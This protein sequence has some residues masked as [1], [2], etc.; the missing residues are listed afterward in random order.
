MRCHQRLVHFSFSNLNIHSLAW[1]PVDI[2]SPRCSTRNPTGLVLL[3]T[4]S[5]VRNV[6]VNWEIVPHA[7]LNANRH[8]SIAKWSRQRKLCAKTTA[9]KEVSV[10]EMRRD[11]TGWSMSWTRSRVWHFHSWD[12]HADV[13]DFVNQLVYDWDTW[14]LPRSFSILLS[15]RCVVR[16]VSDRIHSISPVYWS[17]QHSPSAAWLIRVLSPVTNVLVWWL[18]DLWF[19]SEEDPAEIRGEQPLRTNLHTLSRLRASSC[20]YLC[21]SLLHFS[22]S[23]PNFTMIS[24][25]LAKSRFNSII[26]SIFNWTVSSY[27]F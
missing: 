11:G 5:S 6:S 21:R 3:E 22:R 13:E 16:S 9:S 15:L 2:S 4:Y 14:W 25:P 12:V 1:K 18:F 17:I 26:F 23:L 24:L 27:F 10:P 7:A 19:S 20:W 8:H